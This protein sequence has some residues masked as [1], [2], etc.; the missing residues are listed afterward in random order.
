MT[1]AISVSSPITGT[2]KTMTFEAG[3]LAQLADGA[4]LARLG[5]TMLLATVTAAKTA[6]VAA[7]AGTVRRI[8]SPAVTPSANANAA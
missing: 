5:D 6:S 1:D 7:M 4:V 3:H 8:S 2:E